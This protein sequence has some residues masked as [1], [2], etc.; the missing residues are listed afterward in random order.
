MVTLVADQVVVALS[1]V[2]VAILK[3][4]HIMKEKSEEQNRN[5][6]TMV[7]GF[8]CFECLR[9][10]ENEYEHG[11]AT[12]RPS[13]SS[14]DV[15]IKFDV[16]INSGDLE[17]E[18]SVS[19]GQLASRMRT[20]D[21][22]FEEKMSFSICKKIIQVRYLTSVVHMSIINSHLETNFHLHKFAALLAMLYICSR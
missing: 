9:N 4:L 10:L 14:G 15:H 2:A 22:T 12:W 11:Y 13:S 6:R 19:S 7:E 21:P 5:Q 8:L 18:T 20:S 1:H 16:R 3:E 17:L